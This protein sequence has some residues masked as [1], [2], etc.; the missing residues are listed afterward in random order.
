VVCR[1]SSSR[2]SACTGHRVKQ[3]RAISTYVFGS[4]F[5]GEEN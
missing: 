2:R 4:F 3:L 5:P 1:R